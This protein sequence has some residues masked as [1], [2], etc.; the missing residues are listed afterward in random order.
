MNNDSR[1]RQ[2]YECAEA[3]TAGPVTT[4][5]VEAAPVVEAVVAAPAATVEPVAVVETVTASPQTSAQ[6]ILDKIRARVSD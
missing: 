1:L 5:A 4:P 6:A 3:I 2:F